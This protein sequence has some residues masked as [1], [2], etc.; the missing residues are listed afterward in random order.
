MPSSSWHQHSVTIACWSAD[1][2][3][4]CS[5]PNEARSTHDP[6][7]DVD[8]VID[9]RVEPAGLARV[10]QTLARLLGPT[11]R[12]QADLTRKEQAV[13]ERMA[14]SPDLGAFA[15]PEVKSPSDTTQWAPA[16]SEPA[17]GSRRGRGCRDRS[18]RDVVSGGGGAS[19]DRVVG[20]PVVGCPAEGDPMVMPAH[21]Y[22]WVETWTQLPLPRL[23]DDVVPTEPGPMVL[24]LV[25]PCWLRDAT[26]PT[27]GGPTGW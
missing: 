9:L 8:I 27:G 1:R 19:W 10:H 23:F 5:R 20:A 15:I 26:C 12:E 25:V 2:W 21:R 16:H 6:T 22:P 4:F 14:E 11:D 18:C 17:R 24:R 3:C 7:D 13:L